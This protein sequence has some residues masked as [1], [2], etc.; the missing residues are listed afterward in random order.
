MEKPQCGI[1]Q[2]YDLDKDEVWESEKMGDDIEYEC[3][4][5]GAEVVADSEGN[6][7]TSRA[8]KT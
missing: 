4:N 5:C 6:V 7:H 3:N 1:C 8:S 2:S